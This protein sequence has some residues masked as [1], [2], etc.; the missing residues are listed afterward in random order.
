MRSGRG[1]P[2][3]RVPDEH[4]DDLP[5]TRRLDFAFAPERVGKHR[6]FPAIRRL[7]PRVPNV[8]RRH[9]SRMTCAIRGDRLLVNHHCSHRIDEVL[10][11]N[12]PRSAISSSLPVP[13]S[14]NVLSLK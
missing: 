10:S 13:A 7:T 12:E 14:S 6:C 11:L 4:S 1:R 8:H 9:S 3:I 5:G 2:G